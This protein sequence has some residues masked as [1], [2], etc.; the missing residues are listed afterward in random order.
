MK[1]FFGVFRVNTPRS[2]SST[3]FLLVTHA[4]S[5]EENTGGIDS[6]KCIF[7]SNTNAEKGKQDRW[8]RRPGSSI[9]PFFVA[10]T[11]VLTSFWRSVTTQAY[12]NN[13]PPPCAYPYLP[14][15]TVS[16]LVQTGSATYF[17]SNLVNPCTILIQGELSFERLLRVDGSFK[18][19]LV[20]T[21]DLVVGATG[22]VRGNIEH[23]REVCKGCL[24]TTYFLKSCHT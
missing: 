2:N 19:Q 17:R 5:L 15:D 21:G 8:H 7:S 24:L 12:T 13:I 3:C 6:V 10:S 1:R 22:V 18:G 14:S 20:S 4:G 23:L 11:A 16:I 9:S